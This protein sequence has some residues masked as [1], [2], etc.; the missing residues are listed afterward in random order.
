MTLITN[1]QTL[2]Q[3]KWYVINDQSNGQ[4]GKGNENDSTIKFETKALNHSFVIIQMYIF[5]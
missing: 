4:Y 1:L 3:K 2:Q 5:L